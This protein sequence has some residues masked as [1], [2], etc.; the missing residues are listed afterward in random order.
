MF[1]YRF[2]PFPQNGIIYGGLKHHMLSTRLAELNL[3]CDLI[4][5]SGFLIGT[6]K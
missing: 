3:L 2:H 5:A 4:G 1:H 6:L